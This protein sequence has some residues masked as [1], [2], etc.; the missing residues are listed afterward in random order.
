MRKISTL[1]GICAAGLFVSTCIG[2]MT[3]DRSVAQG[4]G[5]PGSSKDVRVV[6][7]PAEAVPVAVQGTPGVNVANTPTVNVGTLPPVQVGNG[8]GNPV[9]VSVTN[10]PSGPDGGQLIALRADVGIQGDQTQGSTVIYTVPAGKYLVV[11]TLSFQSNFASSTNTHLVALNSTFNSTPVITWVMADGHISSGVS[12]FYGFEKVH[13]LAG[14]GSTLQ[15]FVRRNQA[16]GASTSV[17]F[18]NV[19]LTGRLHDA[20]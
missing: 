12:S 6:N 20:P 8:A 2:L 14:A 7:T 13:H 15:V 3:A 17:Q 4:G 11:E 10:L 5:G 9:P 1:A 18:T 19:S 16:V